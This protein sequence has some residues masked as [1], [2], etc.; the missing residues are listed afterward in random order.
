MK[1]ASVLVLLFYTLAALIVF[2]FVKLSPDHDGGAPGLGSMALIFFMVLIAL[3][4]VINIIK[5]FIIKRSFFF[6]ALLH[7]LILLI[8]YFGLFYR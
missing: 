5:G 8:L 7:G 3:L 1:R 6:I 4:V 2:V